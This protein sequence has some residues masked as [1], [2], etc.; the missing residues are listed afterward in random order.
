ME[1]RLG[2]VVGSQFSNAGAFVASS[3]LMEANIQKL[4]FP[5]KNPK[6][7]SF[8]SIFL[9]PPPLV[10]FSLLLLGFSPKP[11]RNKETHVIYITYTN[12]I[13]QSQSWVS[14]PL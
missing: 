9:F 10:G 12:T 7:S 14:N 11:S 1:L 5:Y 6:T 2:A 4:P 8:S 3:V 13:N